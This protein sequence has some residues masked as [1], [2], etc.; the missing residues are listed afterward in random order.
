[1]AKTQVYKQG[2]VIYF[3]GDRAS[4]IYILRQGSLQTINISIETG[5][6]TRDNIKVGEFFGVKSVLGGYPYDETIQALTDSVVVILSQ[7][8]FEAL[9]TKN[10]PIIMKTLRVFSNQL[11]RVRKKESSLLAQAEVTNP[12]DELFKIALHYKNSKNY[13]QALY[14]FE[15]YIQ[16]AGGDNAFL[17]DA[18]SGIAECKKQIGVSLSEEEKVMSDFSIEVSDED[19]DGQTSEEEKSVKDRYYASLSLFSSG[20]F[21]NAYEGF[22]EIASL[23]SYSSQDATFVE[24]AS[25]DMGKCLHNQKKY[26]EA[27]T[28]LSSVVKKDKDSD[29]AKEALL[30]IGKCFEAKKVYDKARVYYTKASQTGTK[31]DISRQA[32]KLL[33]KL[34]S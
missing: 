13:P 3:E 30:I 15:K 6:E 7:A 11:R 10:I 12:N 5:M 27:I 9:G 16:Y 4:Y 22:S 8:E 26:N 1:M 19:S 29:N 14:A 31:D 24:K 21:E 23:K 25:L 32:L 34:P 33:D 28:T 18:K 2:S 20:D 17:E